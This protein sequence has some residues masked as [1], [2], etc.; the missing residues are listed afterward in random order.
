MT[1]TRFYRALALV[2]RL[3]G[4]LTITALAPAAVSQAPPPTCGTEPGMLSYFGSVSGCTETSPTACFAGEAVQF[5]FRFTAQTGYR[6]SYAWL[7]EGG[8][9]PV[10]TDGP[11][12]DYRYFSSGTF[13]AKVVVFACYPNPTIA[14]QTVTVVNSAAIPTLSRV[15]LMML[16]LAVS[17]VAITALR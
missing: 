12:L 4:I 11:T 6:G 9:T 14:T 1:L 13:P 5:R 15:A 10:Y 2:G 3:A 16:A 7:P 8:A 17:L